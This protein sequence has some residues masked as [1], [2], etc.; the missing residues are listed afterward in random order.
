MAGW[1]ALSAV[2][3]DDSANLYEI[4]ENRLRFREGLHGVITARFF[5]PDRNPWRKIRLTYRRP[6]E[7]LRLENYVRARLVRINRLTATTE[8]TFGISSEGH[9]IASDEI[10]SI[11]SA[12]SDANLGVN[13]RNYYF[14]IEVVMR[15]WLIAPDTIGS[16]L[17]LNASESNAQYEAG[18][19]TDT[20]TEVP[21]VPI[22]PPSENEIR[23][24]QSLIELANPALI[25][26]IL[27]P[28]PE[29]IGV[30]LSTAIQGFQ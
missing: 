7:I 3:T 28:S 21:S 27:T 2:V 1:T 14:Y 26:G 15:R 30:E 20:K 6:G 17:T 18:V 5:V 13:L 24:V 10:K 8:T 9:P 22:P 29:L 23:G 12:G 19:D 16:A 4:V 25:Y 11:Q